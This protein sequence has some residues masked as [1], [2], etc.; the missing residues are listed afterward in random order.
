MSSPAAESP[1]FH[2]VNASTIEEALQTLEAM[3]F[4][5]RAFDPEVVARIEELFM[6]L[7]DASASV[8]LVRG[9]LNVQLLW[10]Q[11][12]LSKRTVPAGLKA[13]RWARQLGDRALLGK[14][15]TYRAAFAVENEDLSVGFEA[16]V[17]A[18][19]IGKEIGDADRIATCYNN[20]E[21][22]MARVG[23]YRAALH[24]SIKS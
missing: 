7:P 14:A 12:L 3:L 23:R 18:L 19:Q 10:Y 21:V 1:A 20:L 5:E 4:A 2:A 24:A 13:V 16:L 11:Q 15:L 8:G 6:T 9:L 17:E 22:I